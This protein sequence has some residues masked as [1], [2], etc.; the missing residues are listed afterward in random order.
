M[1]AE[2]SMDSTVRQAPDPVAAD[3]SGE[4]VMMDMEKGHY[5]GLGAVGSR[6]WALIEQPLT[7]AEICERLQ[8][9]YAV[10]PTT[11]ERDVL[12]F[13]E[14]LRSQRLLEVTAI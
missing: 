13:L 6:I 2:L 11:C 4:V 3:L 1:T 8:A 14:D 5:Y 12:R 7:V 10:D 9:E